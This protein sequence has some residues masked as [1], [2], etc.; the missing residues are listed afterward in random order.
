[1]RSAA[2]EQG[3]GSERDRSGGRRG[4]EGRHQRSE[5]GAAESVG[6][7]VGEAAAEEEVAQSTFVAPAGACIPVVTVTRA[8]GSVDW[9]AGTN[10]SS[11]VCETPGQPEHMPL[12]WMCTWSPVT[13][14][15]NICPPSALTSGARISRHTRRISSQ[16]VSRREG[17]TGA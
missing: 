5:R 13:A 14:T 1:D 12:K 9:I 11:R 3:G 7:R 17:S 2:R 8:F 16:L 10:T 15:R 6:Q 4:H